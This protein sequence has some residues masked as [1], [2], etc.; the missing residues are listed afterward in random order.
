MSRLSELSRDRKESE[1][2][3]YV[4]KR[5]KSGGFVIGLVILLVGLFAYVGKDFFLP[6]VEV[7][8]ARAQ[9]IK[10]VDAVVPKGQLAFQSAGWIE[11]APLPIR[12]SSLVAGVVKKVHV[13]E[14]QH[15]E[16]GSLIAELID[17]DV[18]LEIEENK[19]LHKQIQRGLSAID[20]EHE[21]LKAKQVK[22]HSMMQ[23]AKQT[24]AKLD[25]VADTLEESGVAIA[26]LDRLKAR[27]DALIQR[28]VVDEFKSEI[29]VLATLEE[30]IKSRISLKQT[31]LE[32]IANKAEKLQLELNRTKIYSPI[33]GVIQLLHQ[34]GGNTVKID[35]HMSHSAI[36]AELYDPSNLQVK[37]D[38]P[39][40]D[41]A[42]LSVGQKATIKV[43]LF[44]DKEFDGVVTSIVGQADVTRNTLQ[45]KVKIIEPDSHFRP[46]M[47]A[48][49]KFFSA[50]QSMDQTEKVASESLKVYIP[51]SSLQNGDSVWLVDRQ[52]KTVELV[53]VKLGHG[54]KDDWV[55]VVDGVKPGQQ[56]I[57]SNT[58][59]L[60][61]GMRVNPVE[62]Q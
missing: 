31:E 56:V 2:G 37:V 59:K 55:E 10:S 38:V 28:A 9:A 45:A 48:R 42:G 3:S 1:Q 35:S 40:T 27:H 47:L 57:I 29:M 44:P 19:I 30:V 6:A 11:P 46:E 18:L 7:Q 14:G 20:S 8:V 39:L 5:S 52:S 43:E 33:K 61:A 26:K 15:V 13:L 34:Y 16:K 53:E 17:D 51:E 32:L 58:N 62:S 21:V 54:K 41:V 4:P 12:A 25:Q 50:G 60:I 23:T 22:H 36:I 49:V 24:M